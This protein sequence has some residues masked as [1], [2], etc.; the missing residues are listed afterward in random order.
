MHRNTIQKYGLIHWQDKH[1][2]NTPALYLPPCAVFVLLSR[3]ESVIASLYES[4]PYQCHTCGFRCPTP[5]AMSAHLDYHFKLNRRDAKRQ[6]LRAT[7]SISQQ[8]Y[9]TEEEWLASDDV[10]FGQKKFIAD[11]DED[12][13]NTIDVDADADAKSNDAVHSVACDESQ[14]ICPVDQEPFETYWDDDQEAWMYRACVRVHRDGDAE[15]GTGVNSRDDGVMSEKRRAVNAEYHG[16]IVHW[17]C[18][19]S[20]LTI[21]T[22][23]SAKEQKLSNSTKN[24][25]DTD[26]STADT[27]ETP[28]PP[29]EAVND[30]A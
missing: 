16:Q 8:Y 30:S 6:A 4:I 10:I 11:A 5:D 14:P 1:V 22:A 9:W 26:A 24:E 15:N 28:P 27:G 7:S 18:Y 2:F 23:A 21:P 13:N 20:L 29:L 12:D 19:Q 17:S 25:N 3:D